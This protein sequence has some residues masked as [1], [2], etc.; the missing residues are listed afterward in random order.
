M[1]VTL[2]FAMI[3]YQIL[4]HSFGHRRRPVMEFWYHAHERCGLFE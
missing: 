2:R 1:K 3:K 4:I